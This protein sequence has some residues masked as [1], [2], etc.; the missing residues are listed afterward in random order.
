MDS[1][2]LADG[3]INRSK[4]FD[5]LKEGLTDAIND[6]RTNKKTLRRNTIEFSPLIDYKPNEIRKVRMNAGLTQS[7]FANFLGVS[8]KTVEAWE[9][10]T[11]RLSGS[12]NRLISM[13]SVDESLIEK[14]PFVTA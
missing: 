3:G 13:L 11:N 10:G 4:M 2:G 7:L 6:A 8:K 9:T 5:D 12:S 1:L 14:F